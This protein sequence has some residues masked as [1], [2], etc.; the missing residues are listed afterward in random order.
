M[1]WLSR[2]VSVMLK[3]EKSRR[4]SQTVSEWVDWTKRLGERRQLGT[5]DA[6]VRGKADGDADADADGDADAD[7]DAEL[8]EPA[9]LA[10]GEG[11]PK[12]LVFQSHARHLVTPS[13]TNTKEIILTRI[14]D[15]S[16]PSRPQGVGPAVVL[17]AARGWWPCSNPCALGPGSQ[18][19]LTRAVEL[20]QVVEEEGGVLSHT[21]VGS[22]VRGDSKLSAQEDVGAGPRHGREAGP[23][24]CEETWMLM[25]AVVEGEEN[26]RS[27]T[28]L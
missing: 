15:H 20:T 27:N 22:Y 9:S 2:D 14:T 6:R 26:C 4:S 12:L 5:L 17:E 19:W 10:L 24:T 7:A 18:K 11:T 28:Q 8:I 3:A 13:R 16:I 23:A 25:S 21:T 1:S